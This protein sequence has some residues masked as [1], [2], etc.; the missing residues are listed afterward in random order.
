[1]VRNQHDKFAGA[2]FIAGMGLA[3]SWLGSAVAH[4]GDDDL[5]T[6]YRSLKAPSGMF[7][8]DVNDCKPVGSRLTQGGWQ[9]REGDGWADVPAKA[10]LTRENMAGEAVACIYLGELICFVPPEMG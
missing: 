5:A 9:I 8:C 7:C 6:W 3:L 2:C 1:M 4:P 10:V